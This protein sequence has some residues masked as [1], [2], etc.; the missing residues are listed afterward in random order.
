M[1]WSPSTRPP[2]R[3]L[4]LR[5]PKSQTNHAI[6]VVIALGVLIVTELAQAQA[7]LEVSDREKAATSLEAQAGNLIL[8][9]SF[10]VDSVDT[11]H[12]D[13]W[14]EWA[15]TWWQLDAS[16]TGSVGGSHAGARHLTHFANYPYRVYTYQK[17]EGLAKGQYTVAAWVKSGGGQKSCGICAKVGGPDKYI[18]I[19]SSD[20]WT[21]VST[22]A[23]IANGYIE[24]GIWSD[25]GFGQYAFVDDVAV[26]SS[27]PQESG[28]IDLTGYTL[29]F[30]ENFDA[31]SVAK[32]DSKGDKTWFYWPPYGASGA[33]SFSHW[34]I[35]NTLK[36]EGG[37]LFNTAWWDPTITNHWTNWRTGNLSSMDKFK[38]G[39]ASKYGYF[40]CRIKMPNAG[41]GAW[42]AFWLMGS[43]A[44]PNNTGQRL[45]IDI[46]EW[47]GNQQSTAYQ[48]VHCWN[49]DGS[50]GPLTGGGGTQIPGGDAINTWHI[51]GCKIDPQNITFYIDGQQTR[52]MPTPTDYLTDRLFIMIDYALGGGWPVDGVPF[53]THGPSTMLV[54]WVR[55]YKLP[56]F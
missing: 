42:P 12:P 43:N 34:S 9:P 45:E 17:R 25:A 23:S 14:T 10:D 47:Y 8:N 18:S 3:R 53:N 50:Q 20:A 37:V 2:Q 55:V 4:S 5:K 1:D 16:Y 6:R 27:P 35:E 13:A 51:Y 21:R 19:P 46:V 7:N 52:Q 33:Y 32:T 15:E 56:G 26:Y 41:Q 40:A 28:D 22:T 11:Q 38:A 39:F 48:N 29:I 31:L 36:C 44:I 54:D 24:V 49:A 30:E